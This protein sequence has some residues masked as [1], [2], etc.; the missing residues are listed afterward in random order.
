MLLGAE[1]LGLVDIGWP[2]ALCLSA[3][4]LWQ[5]YRISALVG[6]LTQLGSVIDDLDTRTTN[7]ATLEDDTSDHGSR[8][9]DLESRVEEIGGLVDDLNIRVA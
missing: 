9:S 7:V 8:L 5:S 3:V 1:Y 6:A 2:L 4:F